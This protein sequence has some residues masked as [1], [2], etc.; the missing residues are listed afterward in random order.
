MSVLGWAGLGLSA[1]GT[2]GNMIAQARAARKRER[3]L[4]KRENE[5]EAWYNRRY[6]EVGTERATAQA[7]LSAMR[8]AQKARMQRAAGAAAVSNA[9]SESVAAE[10]AAGNKAIGD[11]VS[12]ITAQDDARKDKIDSQYMARK[13][14]IQDAR[15][16]V[17]TAKTQNIATATGQ[18]VNTAGS[19]IANIDDSSSNKSASK[20]DT[21]KPK[22]SAGSRPAFSS[23]PPKDMNFDKDFAK[24]YADKHYTYKPADER[25]KDYLFNSVWG[26]D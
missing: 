17:E 16:K 12:T 4:D 11:T 7:A 23:V 1:L 18:L 13:S 19:M 20:S 15:D 9:S 24:D 26:K 2:A 21:G 22:S 10:K 8:D 5:N 14:S 3:A 6:N 25:M